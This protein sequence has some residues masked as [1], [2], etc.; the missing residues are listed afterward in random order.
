MMDELV[1]FLGDPI[2]VTAVFWMLAAAETAWTIR[3]VRS[4]KQLLSGVQGGG[5][6]P[7]SQQWLDR[8]AQQDARGAPVANRGRLQL[9]ADPPQLRPRG[10][11]TPLS[12]APGLL[13]ALGVLGTFLG[14]HH[15]LGSIDFASLGSTQELLAAARGLLDGMKTAFST[16]VVGLEFAAIFMVLL[17]VSRLIRQKAAASDLR[18]WRALTCPPGQG[19]IGEA[20]G[21]MAR[22]VT[23]MNE[24]LLGVFGRM[25]EQLDQMAAMRSEQSGTLIK[26]VVREFREQALEPLAQRLDQSAAV[27]ERAALAVEKLESSLGDVSTRLA[28]SVELLEHFQNQTHKQLQ[29]FTRDMSGTLTQFQTET[30]GMLE[31]TGGVIREA[32]DESISGMAR[33]REAFEESADKAA[34]TFRGIR[35]DLQGALKTQSEEQQ[36]MLVALKDANL[37]IIDRAEETYTK[38]AEAIGTVGEQAAK[39]MRAAREELEAGL[40]EVRAG[41][42]ETSETV[43]VELARF[44]NEYQEQLTSYLKRQS[45]ALDEVLERQRKGLQAVVERL[46]SSFEE[47][48]RRRKELSDEVAQTIQQ[49]KEGAEVLDHLATT[50][51]LHSTARLDQLIELSREMAG[52]TTALESSYRDLSAQHQQA[53]RESREQLTGYL[54]DF[55]GQQAAVVHRIDD[56]AARL[57][58]GLYQAA[59]VLVTATTARRSA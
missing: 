11:S 59:D 2:A 12:A 37:A 43:K 1:A 23:S 7:D 5:S 19:G 6:T 54:K 16:S 15:G 25:E 49:L 51:G 22:A 8:W 58:E 33:Q 53:V 14:I 30:Q 20:A 47:E 32:V 13:T 35:E 44:R 41:L 21:Q 39:T 28:G 3:S 45:D 55:N 29:Q 4:G 56:A 50:L 26:E 18:E 34:A 42:R 27:S 36:A 10:T 46:E 17:A 52:Q 24:N 31:Q 48:Y 38:Q 9:V 40:S 57:T